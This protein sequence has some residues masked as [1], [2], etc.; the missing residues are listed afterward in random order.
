MKNLLQRQLPVLVAF[1]FGIALW[2]QY[3]V[4][5]KLSQD[6]L[7][8]YNASWSISIVAAALV[9]GVLSALH[10]HSTKIRLKKP[11]HAYSIVTLV[12]FGIV[13]LFS[14]VLPAVAHL[15][16]VFSGGSVDLFA[17]NP[18]LAEPLGDGTPFTWIFNNVQV[19]LDST[20]FSM[21]C[22]FIA[23][24]A[25][26]AFRARSF[27]ATALLIAGCIVMLGRVPLGEA[28]GWG[29]A[30]AQTN[31]SGLAEW[32][33]NFPSTGAQRGIALGIYMS[34]VALSLRIIFGIERTYMGGA[35]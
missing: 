25:F 18:W 1:C 4:P 23:S 20:M 9:L 13:S 35:D 29:G 34:Q 12:T 24:A 26:R 17:S 31:L 28:M 3:Y 11:G 16:K 15:L 22:F 14:L 21:L 27:E 10:Y 7:Q 30:G 2:V 5:S 32:I 19:P 33:L 6:A 8:S